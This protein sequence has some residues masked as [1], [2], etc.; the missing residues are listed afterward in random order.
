MRLRARSGEQSKHAF[1]CSFPLGLIDRI[2]P[3]LDLF[4]AVPPPGLSI[5][6]S[7]QITILMTYSVSCEV[8]PPVIVS[9]P[10]IHSAFYAKKGTRGRCVSCCFL[11]GLVAL[12]GRT[13]KSERKP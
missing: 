4:H 13:Y 2:Y 1:P 10:T 8:L 11:V 6:P 5:R 12:V 9:F 3:L 7:A